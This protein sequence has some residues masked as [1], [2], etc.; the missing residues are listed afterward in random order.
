MYKYKLKLELGYA[1]VVV[2]DNQSSYH[3]H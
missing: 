1:F 3:C 2:G